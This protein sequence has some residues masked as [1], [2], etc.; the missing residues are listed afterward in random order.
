MRKLLVF[1]VLGLVTIS[2]ETPNLNDFENPI[3][4]TFTIPEW[5]SGEWERGEEVYYI[6]NN[7]IHLMIGDNV[8]ESRTYHKTNSKILESTSQIFK[9][10]TDDGIIDFEKVDSNNI[11]VKGLVFKRA[12]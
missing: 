6:D 4:E 8:T 9:I 2:C 12:F 5:L 1:L 11:K 3:Q 7:L 10:E